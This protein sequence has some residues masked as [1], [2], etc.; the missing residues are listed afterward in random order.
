MR[1]RVFLGGCAGAQNRT[2]L[3]LS[4]PQK[5]KSHTQQYRESFEAIAHVWEYALG[6]AKPRWG[7]MAQ[8][9]LVIWTGVGRLTLA[10]SPSEPWVAKPCKMHASR[11]WHDSR[12]IWAKVGSLRSQLRPH[13][14]EEHSVETDAAG[15]VIG[16]HDGLPLVLKGDFDWLRRP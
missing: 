16:G 7:S 8:V 5:T 15:V 13:P 10:P 3:A 6:S 1:S 9:M 14:T 11:V 12:L 4:A 2:A